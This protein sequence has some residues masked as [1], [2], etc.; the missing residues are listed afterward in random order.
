MNPFYKTTINLIILASLVACTKSSNSKDKNILVAGLLFLQSRTTTSTGIGGPTATRVYGQAGS[1]TT[2]TSNK[3]GISADSLN[4]PEGV[5]IDS[6]G[7]LYIADISNNRVLYYPAGTT[8]AT[9]VYGQAGSFTT[10]TGSSGT[11]SASTLASPKG[12]LIDSSGGVYI[13]NSGRVLYYPSGTTTAT[14]VYGQ[15]GSF[16]TNTSNIAGVTANSLLGP[17]GLALDS[18]N[19]LYVA[20]SGNNRVLYFP[21]GTTTPTRVYGQL[22]SF[23]NS[24]VDPRN[25]TADTLNNPTGL[26]LDKNNGLYIADSSNNRVLYFPSGTIVPTK[27][28]GQSDFTSSSTLTTSASSFGGAQYITI[29]STGGL[30]VSCDNRVAYFPTGTSVATKVYGQGGSFISNTGNKGGISANSLNTPKGIALDASERL[31]IVDTSNSR[32]LYY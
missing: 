32:V 22:G 16:T 12:V 30:Y 10:N 21:S 17:T 8:T 2:L 13:S 25:V 3:G 19:G 29:D 4:T 11:V 6:N 7:N 15:Q 28:Y 26:A 24:I 5:T 20:D 27:V 18:S 9:R 23:T 31:Y 14:V 1:F